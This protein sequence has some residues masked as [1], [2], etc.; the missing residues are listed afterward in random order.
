MPSNTFISSS[1]EQDANEEINV[2][3]D[4]TDEEIVM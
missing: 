3:E 1:D 2:I 4:E